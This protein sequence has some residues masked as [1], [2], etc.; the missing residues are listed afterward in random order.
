MFGS[1]PLPPPGTALFGASIPKMG[2]VSHRRYDARHFPAADTQ[3][4]SGL[5]LA[6]DANGLPQHQ[7]FEQARAR[8]AARHP[9]YE[10]KIGTSKQR[11]KP[12]QL[13][14]MDARLLPMEDRKAAPRSCCP[15]RTPVLRSIDA[16]TFKAQSSF[17]MPANSAAKA[18]CQSGSAQSTAAGDRWTGARS[19][20]R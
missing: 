6:H 2:N 4:F 19:K 14:D 13:D 10:N 5:V 18:S 8:E 11:V 17:T 3:I 1:I 9:R 16:S 15:R 12:L 20:T 7:A